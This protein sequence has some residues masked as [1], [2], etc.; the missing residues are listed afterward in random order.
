MPVFVHLCVRRSHTSVVQL[1][2]SLQSE[3]SVHAE[4]AWLSSRVSA[5]AWHDADANAAATANAKTTGK[6]SPRWVRK[7]TSMEV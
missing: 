5:G 3:L 2:P 1:S 4:T 6:P 7:R